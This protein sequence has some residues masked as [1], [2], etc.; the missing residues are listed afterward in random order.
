MIQLALSNYGVLAGGLAITLIVSLAAIFFGS[1]LGLVISF[2][3]LSKN[4]V[5]RGAAGF[6]RSFW[7]GTPILVQLLLVFYLAPELGLNIA[8][9][10][11][12]ILALSLN[13]AAFQAEI[14]RSGLLAVPQGQL[15]A[16]RILGIRRWQACIW[17][18][19]PQMARLVMPALV[20]E[21]ISIVKNSSLVS[22]IAVTE[23]MRRSQQI[24]ATTF[25]PLEI[26]LI[27]GAIYVAVNFALAQAGQAAERYLARSGLLQS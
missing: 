20:N 19:L 5:I 25:Q 26:F 13:S 8:P 22:I 18:E 24:A 11:A 9:M 3:L 10:T 17:I 7:R 23:L 2:A 16:A 12:A 21:A 6:Y 15:E 4:L 27:A 1:I 14:Y